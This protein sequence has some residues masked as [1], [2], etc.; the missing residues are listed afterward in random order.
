MRSWKKVCDYAAEA[1]KN[2]SA[3]HSCNQLPIMVGQSREAVQDK[4]MEW[5]RTEWD[6]AGWSESTADSAIMGTAAECVAQLK[7]HEQV[8]TQRIVLVPYRY[9]REQIATIA[10]E[11]LP[12]F[13]QP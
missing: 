9:E 3:L 2:P 4:M 10:Q 12:H 1:G 13:A 5:L 11:I 8:G 7:R 6:F